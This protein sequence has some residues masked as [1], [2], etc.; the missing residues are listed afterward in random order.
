MKK[1]SDFMIKRGCEE[2]GN[3]GNEKGKDTELKKSGRWKWESG[4]VRK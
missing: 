2:N 3:G 1:G 4:K